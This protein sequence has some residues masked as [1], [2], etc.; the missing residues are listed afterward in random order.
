MFTSVEFSS[1]PVASRVMPPEP[2]AARLPSASNPLATRTHMGS[3]RVKSPEIARGFAPFS[4][5]LKTF[6]APVYSTFGLWYETMNGAFQFQ[7]VATVGSAISRFMFARMSSICFCWSGVSGADPSPLMAPIC[8]PKVLACTVRA[9]ALWF[10]PVAR[11][12][13]E[14]FPPCVV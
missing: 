9:L 3:A 1:A 11:L 12:R 14:M 13:R 7:R 4:T 6:S 5:D 10:S 2:S 8:W